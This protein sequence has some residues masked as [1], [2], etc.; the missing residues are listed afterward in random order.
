M[1]F[2]K[3]FDKVPHKR[4]LYKLHWYG[5]WGSIHHWIQSFLSNRTQRVIIDGTLS[6]P[7]SVTSGMPQGTVLG[8]LL[9]LVYINDLSDHIKHSTVRLFADDCI[10]HRH[11]QC[12]HDTLLLQEDINSLYAWTITWQ[13]V[14]NTDKCCSMNITLNQLHKISHTYHIHHTQLS[15]V[16]ECKYLGIVIQSDL[17][18]NLHVNQITAKANQTLAMLKR[19]IKLVPKISRIKLISHS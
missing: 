7:V 12:D 9:F 5:V 8:P 19:N 17:R 2:A 15:V 11:I 1:D 3:A 14:L 10:L 6:S 13:I 4:L 16:N 18:W